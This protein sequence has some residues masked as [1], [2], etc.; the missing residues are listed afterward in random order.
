[1]STSRELLQSFGLHN[2]QHLEQARA[3]LALSESGKHTV[4]LSYAALELR[5]AIERLALEYWRALLNRPITKDDLHTASSFKR[6]ERQIYE[7]AGHQR[8]INLHFDFIAMLVAEL[9]INVPVVAPQLGRLSNHWHECS[10][11][12]HVSWPI[13]SRTPELPQK[14]FHSLSEMVDEVALPNSSIRWFKFHEEKLDQLRSDFVAGKASLD[15]AR[16]HLRTVGVWAKVDY[17]D[18]RPS[19]FVGEAIPPMSASADPSALQ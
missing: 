6:I 16:A 15:D 10:E 13:A 11:L 7:L 2:T 8:E 3:W 12:C 18:G 1:M 19:H 4:A 14:A 9:K 17:P 5:F